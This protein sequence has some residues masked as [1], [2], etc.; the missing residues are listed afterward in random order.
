MAHWMFT[1]GRIEGQATHKGQKFRPLMKLSDTP[2]GIS[3]L[4]TIDAPLCIAPE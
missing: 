3:R 1:C 2:K 4:Q